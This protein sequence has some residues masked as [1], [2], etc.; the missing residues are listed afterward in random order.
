MHEI[1]H[2]IRYQ[3]AIEPTENEEY[4]CDAMAY[5]LIQLIKDNQELIKE[6]VAL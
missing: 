6:I 2:T 1:V 4:V 5:G 3:A